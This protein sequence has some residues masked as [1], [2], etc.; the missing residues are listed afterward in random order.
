MMQTEQQIRVRYD[1][2]DKMGY[3]YHG[4]YARYFHV[5]RTELLRQLGIS[6]NEL[7][8][9]GI[10]LPVLEMNIKYLKPVL[11]DET[12]L[13]KTFL[14]EVLGVRVKFSYQIYNQNNALVTEADMTLVFVNNQSRKPIRIPENIYDILKSKIT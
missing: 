12:V 9:Q 3:L 5:G 6:D 4:N 14:K 7:E 8:K 2:V 11:Y 13:L 1:E 10:I